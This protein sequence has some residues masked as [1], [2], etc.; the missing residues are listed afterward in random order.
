M[1]KKHTVEWVTI[2]F[3]RRLTELVQ[4]NQVHA[5]VHSTQ[6]EHLTV[7]LL[8]VGRSIP[9]YRRNPRQWINEEHSTKSDSLNEDCVGDGTG[10][11]WLDCQHVLDNFVPC[12]CEM[13]S[14]S[15][16]IYE[17]NWMI[18]DYRRFSCIYW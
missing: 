10:S 11:S 1:L 12:M 17:V 18:S 5:G 8:I 13:A 3:K 4:V 14:V 15:R 16:L 9:A 7:E 6:R 2:L